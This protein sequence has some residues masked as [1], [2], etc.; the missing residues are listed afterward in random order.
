MKT[1]HFLS[2]AKHKNDIIKA[3]MQLKEFQ[4]VCNKEIEIFFCLG[5]WLTAPRLPPDVAWPHTHAE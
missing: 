4:G 2:F 5:L 3:I 1:V